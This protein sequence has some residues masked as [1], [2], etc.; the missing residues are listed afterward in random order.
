MTQEKPNI[1]EGAHAL[2]KKLKRTKDSL[3]NSKIKNREKGKTIKAA[4]DTKY[5]LQ[6]SRDSWKEKCKERE[7]EKTE[8]SK[9]LK[10]LAKQLE[11]KEEVLQR[12][13]KECDELKKKSHKG[14]GKVR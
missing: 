8:L 11:M 7:E 9:E 4:Q 6:E 13:L 3:D 10:N 2:R 14:F 5:A 12:I 1:K